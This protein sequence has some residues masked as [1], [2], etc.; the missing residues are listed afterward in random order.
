[1]GTLDDD[2]HVMAGSPTVDA[3]SNPA[4]PADAYDLDADA[5][6]AEPL[7]RDLDLL[8]RRL[9]DPVVAD[10]GL[11]SAPIADMGPYEFDCSSVDCNQNGV[12]DSVDITLGSSADCFDS[13]ATPV[14][15]VNVCGNPNTIPD[16]CECVA[17]WNRDGIVNS[18]DVGEFVNKA[19]LT[20]HGD[21]NCNGISNSTDVSDFINL[22]F[23]IQ[24]GLRPYSGCSL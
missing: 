1:M 17:D 12:C 8:P 7:P 11:G 10:T 9:D 22:W 18:T 24:A 5:N 14:G 6:T 2:L 20:N 23:E 3:G 16:E 4:L 13:F 19:F 15:G 21:I